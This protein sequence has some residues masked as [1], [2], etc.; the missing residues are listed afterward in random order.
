MDTPSKK[1]KVAP[2]SKPAR[3]KAV[4]YTEPEDF[5]DEA[6]DYAVKTEV[7]NCLFPNFSLLPR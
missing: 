4:K 1:P 5:D 7:M 3:G 6:D 2:K